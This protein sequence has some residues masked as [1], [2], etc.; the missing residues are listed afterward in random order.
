MDKND[1]YKKAGL[2]GQVGFGKRPVVVVI[3]F[4]KAFSS[5]DSDSGA[6]MSDA[7]RSTRVLTDAAREKNIK[8][9]YTRVVYKEN[10]MDL[11]VWAEKCPSLRIIT[12]DSFGSEWDE[13]LDIREEDLIIEKH[14]PSAFFG[15]HLAPIL[16]AMQIDTAILCGCTVGG[17]VYAT[18][19][20]ACSHGFRTIVPKEC[21]SDRTKET[22]DMFL[23]NMNQKYADVMALNDV[24]SIIGD[25]KPLRYD[26]LKD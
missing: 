18:A 4:Q 12:K 10:G 15:T 11:G 1:V 3:D 5:D 21:V 26:F 23:W 14:W 17:C 8:V 25:M 2:G 16:N 24:I 9:V 7:C 20:D 19:V 22:Y 6:D 13:V